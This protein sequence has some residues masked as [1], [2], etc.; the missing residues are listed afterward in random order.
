MC[1][2]E[3]GR[4]SALLDSIAADTG[5]EFVALDDLDRGLEVIYGRP[6]EVGHENVTGPQAGH[7]PRPTHG[8]VADYY[9]DET[10]EWV[11]EAEAQI[12]ERFGYDSPTA[13][14]TRGVV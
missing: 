10:A 14:A 3:P 6:V 8:P 2:C 12:C 7:A 1:A 5:C 11:R 4:Y 13:T 9:D